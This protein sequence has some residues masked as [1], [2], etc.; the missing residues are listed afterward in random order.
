MKCAVQYTQGPVFEKYAVSGNVF[1]IYA[2]PAV[3]VNFVLVVCY[4][5]HNI[6]VFQ[7]NAQ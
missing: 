3:K 4:S 2:F 7:T 6:L 5:V 1:F